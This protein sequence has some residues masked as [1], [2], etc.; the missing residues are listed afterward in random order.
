MEVF[1]GCC[2]FPVSMKK[3]FKEFSLVEIQQT[4]YKLP[5]VKTAEKWRKE[6]PKDF[7]FC[8][9]AF[10][11]ITHPTSSLTWKRSGLEKSKLKSLED[12][13]G[14]LRATKE[15][16]DFWDKTLEICE[17]LSSPVCLV[18]LPA[19][20]KEEEE[21]VKNAEKF[22][23]RIE[24]NNVS[25]ALELRG[26]SEKG[27]KEICKKF[28][29]ISC[30]DPLANKPL[31]FSSK[32]I[33]YFRLHGKYENGKINYKHKYGQEELEKLKGIVENLKV[34]KVFVLFNNIFM[35]EDALRF[36]KLLER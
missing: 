28:D 35:R 4:F 36:K 24:R 26:W 6:A 12:K 32:K 33:A 5:E 17:V 18:Q 25:I 10:Q 11:G 22:F 23:S 9:K 19:S 13:V 34:K 1:V 8:L 29:L 14:F 7:I 20:F 30:V 3:Y 2:G 15:V 21:N 31:N 27:V 16:F